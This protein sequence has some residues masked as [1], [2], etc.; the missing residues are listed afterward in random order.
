VRFACLRMDLKVPFASSRCIGTMTI[1]TSPL[2]PN[3]ASLAT[4]DGEPDLCEDSNDLTA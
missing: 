2:E 3:M 1:N 4:K